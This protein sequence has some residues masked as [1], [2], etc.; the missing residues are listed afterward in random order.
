MAAVT[1]RE[2]T[3]LFW[4]QHGRLITGVQLKSCMV[5]LGDSLA[6]VTFQSEVKKNW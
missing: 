3:L 1:S 5:K 4:R 2:N 6:R